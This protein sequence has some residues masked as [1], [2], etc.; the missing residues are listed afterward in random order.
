[1]P[2]LVGDVIQ[3]FRDVA[4][5]PP[6]FVAAPILTTA[7]GATLAGGTVLPGTY[8]IVMTAI[9]QWGE[10]TPSAELSVTVTGGQ[11][12]IQITAFNGS[13]GN[14]GTFRIYY[15][16]GAGTEGGFI[17]VTGVLAAPINILSLNPYTAGAPPA[18]NSAYLPDTDGSYLRAYTVFRWLSDALHQSSRVVGGL[19]DYSGFPST[20]NFATYIVTG[21][22]TKMIQAWYDG[23]PV[24]FSPTS[25]FFK[26]N[27]VTSSILAGWSISFYNNQLG[28]EL[29]PQPAR[30]ATQTTLASPM[31]VTDTVATL[32]STGGFLLP[33]YGMV[34]FGSEICAYNGISGNQLIGLIRGLGGTVPT[35]W[36]TGTQVNE[37][38]AFFQGRRVFTYRYIPG[39]SS[40]SLPL[41][42]AWEDILVDFMMAKFY[43]TERDAQSVKSH[44]DS[45]NQRL[46]DYMRMNRQIA[47]PQQAGSRDYQFVVF[48]GTRFGGNVIP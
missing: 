1:M 37:L 19:P 32:A 41:P 29:W 38:N 8:Y 26:R 45:F 3:K 21:E 30:T 44:M 11:N 36:P 15:G 2:A 10:S 47:G 40:V 34:K 13:F 16:F 5:D 14:T 18:T 6:Q 12:A 9:N 28:V 33:T 31:L 43:E 23:Y 27:I 25:A 24:S 20:I 46:K 42:A 17:T 35:A 4:L 48:G 39:Q 7:V 22:W